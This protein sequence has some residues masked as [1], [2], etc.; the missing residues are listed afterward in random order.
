MPDLIIIMS[1]IEDDLMALAQVID[2][3]RCNR[4][5]TVIQYNGERPA[6]YQN[7]YMLGHANALGIGDYGFAELK[8]D[9][10]G[11][12]LNAGGDIYLVGC[13][14]E[15]ENAQVLNNGFVAQTLAQNVYDNIVK[16]AG[17]TN[18][19]FGTPG[20]LRLK[21]ELLSIVNPTPPYATTDLF[22]P[23]AR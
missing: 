16:P 22:V 4:G 17:K 11:H 18:G 6:S 14:T 21:G 23:V 2:D 15:S 20:L 8:R 13:N 1:N 7:L 5:A 3:Q 9:F 10:A 12:I 19:V